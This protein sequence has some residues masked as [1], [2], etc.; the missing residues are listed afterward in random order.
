MKSMNH[1]PMRQYFYLALLTLMLG[2][3][4][5][6]LTI[7]EL[8]DEF[9]EFMI[10]Q[11]D[12]KWRG[13][14]TLD[15]VIEYTK[16][17]SKFTE[18]RREFADANGLTGED[19]LLDSSPI[20]ASLAYGGGACGYATEVGVRFFELCG[21]DVRFVQ[22]LN[23]SRK[24]NHVVLDVELSD[25]SYV[26][27]DPIFGHVF[28]NTKGLPY[29]YEQM[30][31]EWHELRSELPE[32]KIRRY[33]YVNGVQFTNWSKNI[34]SRSLKT[35][36]TQC[37]VKTDVVSMWIYLNKARRIAPKIIFCVSL[38]F[39]F[40]MIQNSPVRQNQG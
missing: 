29:N 22:V 28:V 40:L 12:F 9:V 17:I 7:V 8:E 33:S 34:V 32:S 20:V 30:S 3:S 25:G 10:A 19:G 5:R 26:T 24:T 38:L 36:L 27:V 16:V 21:F 1:Q 37:N 14:K 13:E 2:W 6:N 4:V 15:A 23:S 31:S 11:S 18:P 39:G 35:V